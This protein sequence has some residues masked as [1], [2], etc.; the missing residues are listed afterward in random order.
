MILT[1]GYLGYP[2]MSTE[3]CRILSIYHYNKENYNNGGY[4]DLFFKVEPFYDFYLEF[5]KKSGDQKAYY[6]A[7]KNIKHI[8]HA[9]FDY[10]SAYEPDGKVDTEKMWQEI[11]ILFEKMEKTTLDT[12]DSMK[13]EIE[14]N[15]Y[16]IDKYKKLLFKCL[17]DPFTMADQYGLLDFPKPICMLNPSD[18]ALMD[19]FNKLNTDLN[20]V[21]TIYAYSE[22]CYQYI[23]KGEDELYFKYSEEFGNV[24]GQL[25]D[26]HGKIDYL[27]L[28]ALSRYLMVCLSYYENEE[29]VAV[30]ISGC[31]MITEVVCDYI[32]DKWKNFDY[33]TMK[34]CFYPIFRAF[35]I[36]ELYAGLCE[37]EQT[38][39]RYDSLCRELESFY[40]YLDKTWIG[41]NHIV[42]DQWDANRNDGR[43]D[44]VFTKERQEE[45]LIKTQELIDAW[46][47]ED[48]TKEEYQEKY[49][50]F[51]DE[52]FPVP[53]ED[54]DRLEMIEES[55]F[56]A[57]RG[58]SNG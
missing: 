17:Y 42:N 20:M 38:F 54:L 25:E 51:L 33:I 44:G 48:H 21:E 26:Y 9:Q 11:R 12:R 52:C 57:L 23:L 29:R 16:I 43:L 24:L 49:K 10:A 53:E 58:K 34:L 39:M 18:K 2:E 28:S 31:H 27:A 56:K 6:N 55:I 1:F 40:Q 32:G 46:K 41:E 15:P 30:I 50:Q 5:A 47:D 4:E 45:Y 22:I 8:T 36:E 3:L 35:A 7:L 19:A 14:S 37:E 13:A